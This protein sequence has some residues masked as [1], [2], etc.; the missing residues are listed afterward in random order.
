[1]MGK[2][3]KCVLLCLVIVSM[4]CAATVS[5]GEPETVYIEE[6]GYYKSGPYYAWGDSQLW[7]NMS[8][9]D[10]GN[11]DVYIMT[12]TQFSNAFPEDDSQ[13]IAI[14]FLTQSMENVSHAEITYILEMDNDDLF[15]EAMEDIFVVVDNRQCGITPDDADP[16]GVVELTLE[17][18]WHSDDY[19]G[20]LEDWNITF[21]L[22]ILA[23]GVIIFIAILYVVIR[24]LEKRRTSRQPQYQYQP[25]PVYPP[26]LPYPPT[27]PTDEKEPLD[28]RT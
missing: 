18:D 26:T 1:M 11:V 8:V 14:S 15:D 22:V 9:V 17:V 19:L 7:V 24:S 6:G 3:L 13:P 4:T 27:P 5:A 21:C 28:P 10:G 12:S 20:F 2:G 25:P 16:F 23:I